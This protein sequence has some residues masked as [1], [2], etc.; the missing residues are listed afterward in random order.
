MYT[1]DSNASG[2]SSSDEHFGYHITEYEGDRVVAWTEVSMRQHSRKGGTIAG[3]VL[4]R[5]FDAVGYM[6]TLAQS[7]KGTEAFTTD[8]SMHFLRPAPLGRFIIEGRALRFGRRS[9]VVAITVSSPEVPGGPVASGIVTF[10]PV[11][12]KA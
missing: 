2:V 12:P 6:V 7:P 9:S 3:A 4:F 8:M 5:F 10:A 1:A 11:F